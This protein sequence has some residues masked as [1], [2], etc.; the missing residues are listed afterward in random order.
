MT[1]TVAPNDLGGRLLRNCAL[2][3][4]ELPVMESQIGPAAAY[5]VREMCTV[6]AGDLAPDDSDLGA[7]DLL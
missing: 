3:T 5:R 6:C 2:T 1:R 7:A 4:P